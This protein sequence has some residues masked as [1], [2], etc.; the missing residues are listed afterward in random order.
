MSTVRRWKTC[1]FFFVRCF[2]FCLFKRLYLVFSLGYRFGL[3]YSVR[4]YT[5]HTLT[6]KSTYFQAELM[7]E[8]TKQHPRNSFFTKN[9]KINNMIFLEI[10]CNK[11]YLKTHFYVFMN[12]L[13]SQFFFLFSHNTSPSNILLL[14]IYIQPNAFS[15]FP[16]FI[17]LSRARACIFPF[18]LVLL[19][20]RFIRNHDNSSFFLFFILD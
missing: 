18:V 10:T 6:L 2:F 4:M 19:I 15:F 1:V 12:A 7:R 8:W 5:Q 20:S 9:K 13:S 3:F 16:V 14:L 11:T 17:F